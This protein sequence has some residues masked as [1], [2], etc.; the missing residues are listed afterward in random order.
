[1]TN[2]RSTGSSALGW[3]IGIVVV[4]LFL[5]KRILIEWTLYFYL[6]F[7]R[8]AGV[9][10]IFSPVIGWII[11]G[12]FCGFCLGAYVSVKKYNLSR[13]FLWIPVAVAATLVITGG[14]VNKSWAKPER[15][16]EPVVSEPFIIDA[17]PYI[18]A[19]SGNDFDEKAFAALTDNMPA[20]ALILPAQKMLSGMIHFRFDRDSSLKEFTSIRCTGFD[21]HNGASRS[22]KAWESHK[23]IKEA[24]VYR[25]GSRL[26]LRVFF[27]D[28]ASLGMQTVSIEPLTIYFGD[29]LS[30]K[31]VS[32]YP[33][34]GKL[35]NVAISSLVPRIQVQKPL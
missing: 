14:L 32:L 15:R 35:K 16:E 26:D 33:K 19:T 28:N 9:P 23:R 6:F 7:D 34:S 25:N 22:K 27:K 21:I 12:L 11:L 4:A 24:V 20:T 13:R 31:V 18:V 1:M 5:L 30:L 2:D 8:L 17:S 10:L 29:V 3:R